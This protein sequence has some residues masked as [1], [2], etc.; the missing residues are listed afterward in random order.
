MPFD[1]LQKEVNVVR[2]GMSYVH[3]AFYSFF[4]CP[5]F[6]SLLPLQWIFQWM[7]FEHYWTSKL[8]L[9]APEIE[10]SWYQCVEIYD[11]KKN[12]SYKYKWQSCWCCL[13]FDIV[14]EMSFQWL[15]PN[16]QKGFPNSL[17]WYVKAKYSVSFIFLW[18]TISRKSENRS[19]ILS[20]SIR[21]QSSTI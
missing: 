20:L 7:T 17:F 8:Q 14:H 1:Q 12:I 13:L 15:V 19:Y 3:T 4:Y 10:D 2:N 9:S 11:R 16:T 6:W 5:V 21:E 18:S